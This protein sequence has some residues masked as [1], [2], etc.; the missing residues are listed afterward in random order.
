MLQLLKKIKTICYKNHTAT[1]GHK[2]YETNSSFH[3]KE[4][5]TGKV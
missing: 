4:C 2:I 1:T 5:T 3:L